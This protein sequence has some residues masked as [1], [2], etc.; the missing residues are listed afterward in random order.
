MPIQVIATSGKETEGIRI[1]EAMA[2]RLFPTTSDHD[3]ALLP[4]QAVR[5]YMT[6]WVSI[7][8]GVDLA[9]AAAYVDQNVE[10]IS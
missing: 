3:R 8:D 10:D 1:S 5:R 9:E 7:A 2:N 4:G 6:L